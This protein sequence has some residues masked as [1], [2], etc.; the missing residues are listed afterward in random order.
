MLHIHSVLFKFTSPDSS[1]SGVSFS[2]LSAHLTMK[3]V[4]SVC[5]SVCHTHEPHLNS[6]S[7]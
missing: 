1:R 6:S 3:S 2:S 7:Y 4:L 5:P